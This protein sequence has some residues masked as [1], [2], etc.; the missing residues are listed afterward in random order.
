MP[1]IKS[2]SVAHGNISRL[3]DELRLKTASHRACLIQTPYFA[4]S[5]TTAGTD[6]EARLHARQSVMMRA[7]SRVQAGLA[8]R[9]KILAPCAGCA[10][11]SKFEVL[12]IT[13][14]SAHDDDPID[15]ILTTYRHHEDLRRHL[16]RS[17]DL[18]RQGKRNSPSLHPSRSRTLG[19]PWRHMRGMGK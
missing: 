6:F 16:L 17:Q 15:R 2:T 9:L 3:V 8:V 1:T 4:L 5:G 11:S 10:A 18:S 14:Q 19:G 12:T 13:R 7:A